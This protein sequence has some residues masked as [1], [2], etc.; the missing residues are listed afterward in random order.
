[1]EGT[2]SV[3]TTTTA[4]AT[5]GAPTGDTARPTMAQAFAANPVPSASP[6]DTSGT[7][8]NV[9]T[10]AAE[11][12]TPTATEQTAPVTPAPGPIPYERFREVNER[13]KAIAAELQTLKSQMES[14]DG[15][16]LRQ[17]AQGYQQ[18]PE[19]WFTQTVA[20]LA[21]SRPD[22]LPALR[23]QAARLLGS[24]QAAADPAAASLDPD[25]PVFDE[26]GRQV[27]TT[28]S[29]SR[30]QEIVKHAV[31]EALQ[32]EVAPMKSDFE[33][34][35]QQQEFAAVQKA[36]TDTAAKQFEAAKAWPGF[37]S[38]AAKGT[39][40][41]D[42]VKAF[43]A[44]PEW[45]LEMAYIQTVVPKLRAKD[46]ADVLDSLKTKAAAASGVNPSGAV[47]ASPGPRPRTLTDKSL[48]WS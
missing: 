21:S 27:N 1:M 24:R 40:D 31:N 12:T 4:P 39:V 48:V 15:Q 14:P 35:K 25:I 7:D 29:A 18:N 37:L 16:R 9:A 23:S 5:S 11:A 28:Y 41:A 33:Q 44:H 34:R 10:P 8:P 38:D 46:Q 32:R 43:D 13:N 47:I 22:L 36:A 2:E 26:S 19:Q 45:S 6:A 20:D 3:G 42:L 17:W 30:V